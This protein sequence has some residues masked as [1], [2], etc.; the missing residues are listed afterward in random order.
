MAALGPDQI[1]QAPVTENIRGKDY[2]ISL[3]DPLTSSDV[4]LIPGIDTSPT[5]DP[6]DVRLFLSPPV[7][8]CARGK[9]EELG[10]DP[11]IP[12]SLFSMLS[13]RS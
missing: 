13:V 11:S 7:R 9:T 10:Q 5:L 4:Y 8:D 3:V 12:G 2:V 1:L 6:R